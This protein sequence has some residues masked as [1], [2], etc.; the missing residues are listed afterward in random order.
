[1][2]PIGEKRKI[3][4]ICITSILF[5]TML[6][7]TT[8]VSA[9]GNGGDG[10]DPGGLTP[11][12]WKNHQ[13]IWFYFMPGDAIDST[14]V[15]FV[16]PSAVSELSGDSILDALRYKGGKDVVGAARILLRS[17]AA[18]I[19]NYE[20][21][22]NDF[23]EFE[24]PMTLWEIRDAVNAALASG[25]RGDILDLKDVLDGYNNLGIS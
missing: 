21:L 19:L 3:K 24:Y 11:G 9:N 7:V 2:I 16:L 14:K 22:G 18:A 5:L 4:T 6:G 1:V 20:Y 25:D 17:A 10:G 12:F 8:S 23:P 13:D 15:G